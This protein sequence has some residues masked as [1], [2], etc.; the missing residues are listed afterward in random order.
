MQKQ[1]RQQDRRSARR[2]AALAVLEALES[3]LT[4]S[5]LSVTNLNDSG[6]GSL[7]QAMSDAVAGDTIN[8]QPG[9][10]GTMNL[11]TDFTVHKSLNIVGPGANL[12]TVNRAPATNSRVM[13]FDNGF[14]NIS[15]LTFSGAT[16]GA[17]NFGESGVRPR[18]T[19]DGVVI[20]GNSNTV[21]GGGA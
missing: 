8:F 9:L 1:S 14:L 15:G 3:R 21:G 10:T 13:L 19:F 16:V 2:Q 20:T 5:T 11:Q 7:R 18:V 6:A 4:L 17:F 12:I